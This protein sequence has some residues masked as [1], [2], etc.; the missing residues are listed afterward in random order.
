MVE[1]EH[2]DRLTIHI[3]TLTERV[4]RLR[5]AAVMQAPLVDVAAY[6]RAQAEVGAAKAHLDFVARALAS[7]WALATQEGAA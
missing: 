5:P 3:A 1:A 7:R 2:F 6:W 4:R